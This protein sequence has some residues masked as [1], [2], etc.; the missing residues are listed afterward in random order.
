[1][2][3]NFLAHEQSRFKNSRC[4]FFREIQAFLR[5]YLRIFKTIEKGQISR[6]VGGTIIR[7]HGESKLEC[8]IPCRIYSKRNHKNIGG[9]RLSRQYP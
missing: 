9:E 1:M 6:T 5:D 7:P 2:I 8:D 3:D 4:N